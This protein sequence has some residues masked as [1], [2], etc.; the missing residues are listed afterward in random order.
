M[1][2]FDGEQH[3]AGDQSRGPGFERYFLPGHVQQI[4]AAAEA[5]LC[6]CEGAQAQAAN[7]DPGQET[8]TG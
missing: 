7:V 2:R 5:D 4:L 1:F 3:K 8:N 6:P